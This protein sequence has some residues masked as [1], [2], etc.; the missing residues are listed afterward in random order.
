M[1]E[2]RKKSNIAKRN[3]KR[4]KLQREHIE[5]IRKFV[6]NQTYNSIKRSTVRTHLYD[7]HPG[8]PEVTLSTLGRCMK[9][10]W[11]L[12]YK[13]LSKIHVSGV[14]HENVRRYFES[15][16]IQCR[17]SSQGVELIFLDEFS[18]SN[19]HWLHRGWTFKGQKGYIHPP[20]ENFSMSFII[21]LSANRV[22]GIMGTDE[23]VNYKVVRHFITWV[24]NYRMMIPSS[25]QI[26]WCLVFDNAS[27][28]VWGNMS[29]FY[30]R[31]G[32]RSISI[33]PYHPSLNPSEHFIL[34]I[35]MNIKKMIESGRWA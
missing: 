3:S 7:R 2:D 32:I 9:Q 13:K 15:A 33:A 27:V 22:Y 8:T 18:V 21:A 14:S 10:D 30:T 17:L 6:S 29:Q 4:K 19:R 23:T 5:L 16:I 12:S 26:P 35:K 31:S 28:H 25:A 11:G 24:L 34:A 20:T 1:Y